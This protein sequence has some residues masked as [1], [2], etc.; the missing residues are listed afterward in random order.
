MSRFEFLSETES[1]NKNLLVICFMLSSL[2]FPVRTSAEVQRRGTSLVYSSWVESLKV[3]R[4]SSSEDGTASFAGFQLSQRTRFK[5]E[6]G[7]SL[8]VDFG[9]LWGQAQAGNASSSLGYVSERKNF[10]GVMISPALPWSPRK[11]ILFKFGPSLLY[12]STKWQMDESETI[13]KSGA[14]INTIALGSL[15]F[16]ISKK[17]YIEQAVGALVFNGRSFWS[18][19]VGYVW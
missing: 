11:Q 3:T 10:L 5:F 9:I 18:L 17:L 12:R 1:I 13:A 19:G 2:L 16:K 6:N 14:D 4:G 7:K 8:F 15:E